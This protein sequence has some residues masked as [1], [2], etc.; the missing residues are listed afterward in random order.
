[1]NGIIT[2]H[3]QTDTCPANSKNIGSHFA[4]SVDKRINPNIGTQLEDPRGSISKSLDNSD[5]KYEYR[6]FKFCEHPQTGAVNYIPKDSMFAIRNDT[7]PNNSTKIGQ[8]NVLDSVGVNSENYKADPVTTTGN[9]FLQYRELLPN[10]CRANQNIDITGNVILPAKRCNLKHWDSK[11]NFGILQPSGETGIF[12]N[13]GFTID[14]SNQILP[15]YFIVQPQ[16]CVGEPKD[17]VKRCTNKEAYGI[18]TVKDAQQCDDNMKLLCE[19][20]DYKD[21][22]LCSCINSK[23]K[24]LSNPTCIDNTCR[25]EGYQTQGLLT[26]PCIISNVPIDCDRYEQIKQQNPSVDLIKN[27]WTNYCFLPKPQEVTEER[28]IDIVERSTGYFWFTKSRILVLML[29]LLTLF[30]IIYNNMITR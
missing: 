28:P 14:A 15:G 9:P 30:I 3:N 17:I 19:D 11:G 27:Q 22:V 25:S 26:T 21:D 5:N 24:T 8:I 4:I 10:M 2:I 6:L 7:C 29:L 20:K 16:L 1:M 13:G 23:V 18:K 12:V